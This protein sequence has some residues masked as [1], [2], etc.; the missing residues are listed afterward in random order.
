MAIIDT[1]PYVTLRSLE[2]ISDEEFLQLSKDDIRQLEYRAE[3]NSKP[4]LKAF[5]CL[6][7]FISVERRELIENL[8][9]E[10]FRQAALE[11]FDQPQDGKQVFFQNYALLRRSWVGLRK[12]VEE[13][14]WD[15]DMDEI[16]RTFA[17][18]AQEE[19]DYIQYGFPIRGGKAPDLETPPK[20]YKGDHAQWRRDMIK[21]RKKSA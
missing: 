5:L 8:S 19:R 11:S 13:G 2:T 15:D 20:S 1:Y 14:M 12:Q 6:E 7:E 18:W 16:R 21:N 3:R 9:L 17:E 10:Q 4:E